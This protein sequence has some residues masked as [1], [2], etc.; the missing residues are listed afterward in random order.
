[1]ENDDRMVCNRFMEAANNCYYRNVPTS[2]DF[3]DIYKQNL[4]N[5]VIRELPPVQY[6][7]DGGYELA[8]RKVI[9]FLPQDS[10]FLIYLFDTK[11]YATQSS[12]Y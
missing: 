6:R 9:M 11:S 4:F 5:T 10:E 7:F 1:M 8:E 3:L 2:T 12:F